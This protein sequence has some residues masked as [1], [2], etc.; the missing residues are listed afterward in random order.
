MSEYGIKI[1]NYS[2][3]SIFEVAQGVRFKYDTTP[4]MLTNSL[5]KDFICA[6][7]L[8]LWK[9]ESTRDII[10]IDYKYG[11]VSY[12]EAVKRVLKQIK[13]NRIERKIA[14]SHGIKHQ[15]QEAEQRKHNLAKRVQLIEAN[16]DKYVRKSADEIRIDHYV[17]GVDIQYPKYNK[18]TKEWDFETIHY[19]MLYRT[20]G[21][22]KKGSCMFIRASLWK[23]AH[24]FLWM[25]IKL[26]KHNAPI[27]EIGAYSSLITSSIEGK[28]VIDPSQ[29]LV[30]KDVDSYFNTK[31]I[32]VELDEAK[33]CKA[34]ERDNYQVKN[35]LFDG[36][37]LI[38]ESIFPD[39]GDGYV[40]LRQHFFKAAAFCTKI[41]KYFK[42][43][44]K[45]TQFI[46]V[47]PSCFLARFV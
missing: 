19:K 30:L 8:K 15:I 14:K 28:V 36:Q 39:W 11:S 2:A 21:K 34:V 44:K 6:N 1:L 12:E 27:V 23:K 40:L 38:D 46:I 41:Q 32:S 35:T 25:G 37:A 5:F 45:L 33:H 42:Q 26:P 17:N 7:G 22:A 18:K 13:A 4:A 9:D 20:P 31:V 10:C 3:G 29:I 24:D 47:V 43:A 16:R